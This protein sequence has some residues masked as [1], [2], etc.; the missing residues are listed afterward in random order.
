M[1][2][3]K[4]CLFFLKEY[5]LDFSFYYVFVRIRGAGQAQQLRLRGRLRGGREG[6]AWRAR[7]AC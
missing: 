5:A 3:L 2:K 6:R 7:A 1:R 4:R